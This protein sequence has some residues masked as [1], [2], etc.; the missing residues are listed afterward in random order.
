MTL[1]EY[2]GRF[3]A[4][5]QKMQEEAPKEDVKLPEVLADREKVKE[6]FLFTEALK[7]E[8]MQELNK[9]V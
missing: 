7:V 2:Q 9:K 5:M 6:M 3:F 8:C 4:S 1:P